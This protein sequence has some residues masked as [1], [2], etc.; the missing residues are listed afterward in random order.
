MRRRNR[1]RNANGLYL[2]E[3][4]VAL[5]LG[6]LLCGTLLQLLSENMRVTSTNANKQAS[7]LAVQ[8]VLDSFKAPTQPLNALPQT[9]LLVCSTQPGQLGPAV[10]PLPVSLDMGDLT[11]AP[12]LITNAFPGTASLNIVAG[13]NNTYAATTTVNWADSEN[14]QGK[15]VNTMTTINLRGTNFWP[16]P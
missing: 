5:I 3:T 11:W 12:N 1:R 4:L 14:I 13:P 15:T 8:T 10:H 16:A 6:T 7:D 2:I 9:G